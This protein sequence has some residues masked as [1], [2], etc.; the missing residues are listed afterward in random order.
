MSNYKYDGIDIIVTITQRLWFLWV[1]TITYEGRTR[2]GV[3]LGATFEGAVGNVTW[4]IQTWGWP[5]YERVYANIRAWVRT[6]ADILLAVYRADKAMFALGD[7][8]KRLIM[9]DHKPS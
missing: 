1:W 7:G 4:A 5:W 6:L 2:R 8:K 9:G 3:S